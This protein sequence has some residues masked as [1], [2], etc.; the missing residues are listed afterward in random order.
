MASGK[1]LMPPTAC[2]K[3]SSPTSPRNQGKGERSCESEKGEGMSSMAAA[4]WKKIGACR[5][6]PILRNNN[7]SKQQSA[8]GTRR[9]SE[10]LL[11]FKANY[12]SFRHTNLHG[13]MSKSDLDLHVALEQSTLDVEDAVKRL[14][15]VRCGQS[16]DGE[17]GHRSQL[18]GRGRC[19]R[20]GSWNEAQPSM[21]AICWT[22]LMPV[23]LACHD[24][25]DRQTVS[26]EWTAAKWQNP[27]LLSPSTARS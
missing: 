18:R 10:F 8:Q 13:S 23:C 7:T 12:S 5:Q 24:F 19:S 1:V 21:M 9:R 11:T 14:D 17:R 15:E 22:I 16:S 4:W 2:R 27:P 25:L 6:R 3:P 26:L 20:R